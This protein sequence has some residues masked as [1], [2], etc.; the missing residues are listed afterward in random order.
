MCVLHILYIY[1]CIYIYLYI[2]IYIY[3]I[4]IY[5]YIYACMY[6]YIHIYIYVCKYINMHIFL[7]R[8]CSSLDRT[9]L[10]EFPQ[11]LTFFLY[12]HMYIYIYVYVHICMCTCTFFEGA[13]LLWF[14]ASCHMYLIYTHVHLYICIYTY[15]YI[16]SF[17]KST[18]HMISRKPSAGHQRAPKSECVASHS[19]WRIW[20]YSWWR[21]ESCHYWDERLVSKGAKKWVCFIT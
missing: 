11:A 4:F 12:I 19:S 10:Y 15:L 3:N 13:R 17:W 21:I 16:R 9:D 1:I 8:T 6:T 5:I 14:P 20:I 2:Y 7:D 18:T